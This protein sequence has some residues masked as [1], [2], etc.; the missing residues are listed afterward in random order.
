MRILFLGES[1]RAD[2]QS[3]FKGI[4]TAS[5]FPVTI[6]EIPST[7]G[8]I[9]R[10]LKAAGFLIDLIFSSEKY[11]IVL[12]ERSTSYGFFSLFVN[13]KVRVVAQQGITDCYP[14]VGIAGWYKRILQKAIYTRADRIHAWG[15]VMTYSMLERGTPPSRIKVKPKGLDLTRFKFTQ[16]DPNQ[17]V[18]A[19]VTRSLYDIYRHEDIL[20]AISIL[21]KKGKSIR[22][23]M[24]GDGVERDKLHRL[25]K[26][27]GIESEIDWLGRISNPELPNYLCKASLYLAVP[28]TEGV[29]SSLFEAMACGC[30]PIVTDLPANRAF[31]SPGVNGL[32]V[33]PCD[34]QSLADQIELYLDGPQRFLEGVKSNRDYIE[35]KCDHV[36]N[37]QEFFLDYQ[38][39]VQSK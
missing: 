10:M 35:Q 9:S 3:W 20:F 24:V 31:I 38:R 19:I 39:L 21:K 33:K 5:G 12:A 34:P 17:L 16:H 1:Y 36:R 8:R 2:A 23:I 30:F 13:T 32:L 6:K 37:M 14:D 25:T 27:L 11:D 29:S 28:T 4:E 18:T 26:S 22:C 7:G 15:Y